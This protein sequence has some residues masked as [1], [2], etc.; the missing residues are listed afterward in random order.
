MCG[1]QNNSDMEKWIILEIDAERLN[2]PIT[3]LFQIAV[4]N[5]AGE[6]MVFNSLED[7]SQY[8]EDEG[9]C[10]KCVELPLF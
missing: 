1:G 4:C 9:I 8:Q 3:H 7:A 2:E 5:D 6:L 10:G